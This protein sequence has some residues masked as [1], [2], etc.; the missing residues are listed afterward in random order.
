[1]GLNL[2]PWT[3]FNPSSL[4][5]ATSLGS[6][7]RF[8]AVAGLASYGRSRAWSYD[9]ST[10]DPQAGPQAGGLREFSNLERAFCRLTVEPM[11]VAGVSAVRPARYLPAAFLNAP[12][13]RACHS[14]PPS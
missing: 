7:L 13:M 10:A 11:S 12:L 2:N 3:A 14:G 8:R 5:P 1:M 4:T 6:F 9:R